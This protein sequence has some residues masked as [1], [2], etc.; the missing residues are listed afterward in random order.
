MAENY[1]YQNFIAINAQSTDETIGIVLDARGANEIMFTVQGDG[2][3][4]SGV[5]TIE[6]ATYDPMVEPAY[7]GTW[8]SISTVNASD[9]TGGA[10]NAV[11]ANLSVV[12]L[13]GPTGPA[14]SA[15]A[16]RPPSPNGAV[17]GS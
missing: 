7:T 11:D 9:V 15:G 3:T 2:T 1:G 8:S 16:R 6:E 4:S 17:V 12:M 13:H 14:G 5:I 10:Q